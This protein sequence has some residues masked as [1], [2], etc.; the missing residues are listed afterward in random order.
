MP[1]HHHLKTSI[2]VVLALSAIAPPAATAQR[3]LA[4]PP[5][6]SACS[7]NVVGQPTSTSPASTPSAIV[8][9]SSN[10][11]FD[12]ADAGVGAAGVL[13]IV[14]VALGLTLRDLAAG[15]HQAAEE[16]HRPGPRGPHHLC[17]Q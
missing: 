10:S 7:Y 5:S 16:Q 9:V 8:R 15:T 4:D 11:G 6:C 2:A 13:A 12:W 17:S 3:P 1:I 14:L